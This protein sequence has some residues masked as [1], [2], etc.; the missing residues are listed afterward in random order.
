V[1]AV[2]LAAILILVF[3]LVGI[4]AGIFMVVGLS[5]RRTGKPAEHKPAEHGWPDDEDEDFELD[6]RRGAD[7]GAEP[8]RPPW[9]HA[10]D[11]Y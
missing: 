11:D 5:A 1:R 10:R 7:P 3:F 2:A 9:W 6:Q 4:A 8:G